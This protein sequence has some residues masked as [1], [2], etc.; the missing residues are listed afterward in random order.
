MTGLTDSHDLNRT[1]DARKAIQVTKY[2]PLGKRSVSMGFPQF[3]YQTPAMDVFLGE[4][5]RYGSLCFIMIETTDALDAVD[6]IAAL[7]GCD[8]LLIGS[9][10][11]ATEIGTMP[12]WDAP[13]FWVGTCSG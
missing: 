8:V 6:D 11:L 10:D 13:A 12:D 5:N 9:Q 2:A 7:P 3:R 1:D 4:M